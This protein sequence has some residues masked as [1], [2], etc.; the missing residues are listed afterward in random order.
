MNR[1]K[2]FIAGLPALFEQL[3]E[4]WPW[5]RRLLAMQD[6]YNARRGNV[7]AAAI[8]FIGI[9]SMVPILMVSFAIAG[10]ILAS[11]PELLSD[12]T[13]AV[14]ENVPGE[15]G[16]QLNDII[17]SAIESR[18]AVGVIG[19]LSAALT[20]LGWM[21]LV[22]MGLSEMWGGRQKRSAVMGKVYDL[23]NFVVLGVLFV[24]TIAITVFASGPVGEWVLGLVGVEDTWWG[25]WILRIAAIIISVVATWLLFSVVL[26]KLPLQQLPIRVVM[27]GAFVTAI[28]FEILK[29][30]GSLYL[31]SVM[32]SPAGAAF[33]PII[34]VMVFGYLAS[35]IVLY[36]SAWNATNP[37]NEQYLTVDE[38]ENDGEEKEPV[39]FAPIQKVSG[40]P[41]A[42]EIVTAAGVGAAVATVATAAT[43]VRKRAGK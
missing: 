26:A 28:V 6:H 7:Y 24:G 3:K 2:A 14:V 19:L 15:L 12:I 9:L 25:K 20:G 34:G 23:L 32:S 4:R 29:S 38:V 40:G 33:G 31:Q 36:A 22:R 17:T 42:R 8:S 1:I 13:D 43:T 30:L 10:F 37:A 21:A 11:R 16:T 27:P 39:Y 18:R 5:L 35:R 41:R